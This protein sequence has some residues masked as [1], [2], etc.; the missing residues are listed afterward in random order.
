MMRHV[1][2]FAV[3]GHPNEGKSAVLSTLAEDDSVRVSPI[4]GETT[5]CR[6]FPVRI[7]GKEIIRFIDTPGFQNPR[8][9][10]EW[11]KAHEKTPN[12]IETFVAGHRDDPGFKDD[13]ALLSPVINGAA[14]IFVVDGSRP[15]RNMDRA[16]MEILRLSGRPRLAV[17]N[18]KEDDSTWLPE[19]QDE[20]RK[21][22]NAV[23][24]F[25]ANRATY[26]ERMSLLESLKAIDQ[27]LESCLSK[28]IHALQAN[29]ERRISHTAGLIIHLLTTVLSYRRT[30]PCRR[31]EENKVKQKLLASFTDF[32]RKEEQRTFERIRR[33]Y[34]HNIFNTELPPQSI[35]QE[36]LFAEK[37][38]KFLGLTDRQLLLAGAI[39]GAAAG[40]S[41]DAATL[42]GSFGAFAVF[43]GLLGAATTYFKAKDILSG[44]RLLGIRLDSERIRMGPVASSQL[45][46]VL[47][48]RSLLFFTLVIN[49]AHG[50]RDYRNCLPPDKALTGKQGFT[51]RWSRKE[52]MVC[53]HFLKALQND[54][55]NAQEQ[56]RQELYRALHTT[57]ENLSGINKHAWSRD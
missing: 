38:W 23:R 16:E 22:F 41:I 39:G 12:L 26:M 43:G 7:D 6:T 21:H 46:Y 3:I 48:D 53:E 47:I 11:M 36:D 33:L 19:W 20:F 24:I 28:V 42:G 44:T 5:E 15:V 51:S 4:P 52:R 50:R 13:C 57:L 45:L 40:V 35:L 27:H 18:C 17:I 9:I 8:H 31:G 56:S 14:I 1:P 10:L 30:V 37:T 32:V 49:W 55:A 34:R 25:N 54:D 2:E 29:Y